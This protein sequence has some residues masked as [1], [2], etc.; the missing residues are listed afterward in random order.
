MQLSF[1]LCEFLGSPVGDPL[2]LC[3]ASEADL[4]EQVKLGV[5]HL[6]QAAVGMRE[7]APTCGGGCGGGACG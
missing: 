1:F 3:E 7:T 6:K 2:L 4:G 5:L